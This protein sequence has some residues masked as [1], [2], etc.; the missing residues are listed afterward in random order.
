[1]AHRKALPVANQKNINDVL[2]VYARHLGF[3][4]TGLGKEL[5][6]AESRRMGDVYAAM[7]A[8][9]KRIQGHGVEA[10]DVNDH[11]EKSPILLYVNTGDNYTPT[12]MYDIP[13]ETFYVGDWGSWYEWREKTYK[14][15]GGI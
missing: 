8:A 6:Y 11:G 10:I 2:G 4:L 9:N 5:K 14:L 13:A 1:M 3:K 15:G 7:D 12:I